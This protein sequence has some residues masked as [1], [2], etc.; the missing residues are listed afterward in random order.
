MPTSGQEV[1]VALDDVTL[2]GKMPPKQM[3]MLL[4]WI[5]IHYEELLANWTLLS[6]GES[7]FRIDPLR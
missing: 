3:K 5:E 7:A 2:E 6:D 1:V 4:A